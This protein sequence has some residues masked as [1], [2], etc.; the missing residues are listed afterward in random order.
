ALAG[1]VS[2]LTS[3]SRSVSAVIGLDDSAVFVHT[4]HVIDKN[5]PPSAGFRNAPPLS[6]FW[7]EQVSPYAYPTGFTGVS[8]PPTAPWSIRGHTPDQIKGAYGITGA[9]TGA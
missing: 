5:A 9:L 2:V 3:L 6:A 4:D 7:A 8:N 1:T